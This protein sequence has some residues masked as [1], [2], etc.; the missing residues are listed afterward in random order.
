MPQ[1]KTESRF[2]GLLECRCI[3][4]FRGGRV[5]AVAGDPTNPP[6][7]TLARCAGGVWKTKDAGTYWECVTDGYFNTASV[8][9]LAVAESDP[10]CDLRRN[11][12]DDDPHRRIAWGRRLQIDRCRQHLDARRSGRHAPYCQNQDSSRQPRFGVCGGAGPRLRAEQAARRLSLQRWRQ[13]SGSR[14]CS[15]ARKPAQST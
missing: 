6:C 13:D 3:G 12:R 8:G 5:V 15:A 10:E 14:C 2:S 11:R 4:P 1:R 9:A 7:F